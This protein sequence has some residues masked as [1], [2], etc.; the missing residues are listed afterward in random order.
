MQI[1]LLVNKFFKLL[2]TKNDK[3]EIDVLI[4][5]KKMKLVRNILFKSFAVFALLLMATFAMGQNSI[6][7]TVQRFNSDQLDR[8]SNNN[9]STITFIV[10]NHL[11]VAVNDT[12]STDINVPLYIF[13]LINDYDLDGDS[14]YF[15]QI[16]TNPQ[17]GVVSI[18]NGDSAFYSP[19]NNYQSRNHL[20]K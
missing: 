17:H 6:S 1:T 12:D 2:F 8:V 5:I 9:T 7:N 15:N 19:F 20:N 10:S 3:V 16:I 18:Y 13:N 11:P 14:I 4:A